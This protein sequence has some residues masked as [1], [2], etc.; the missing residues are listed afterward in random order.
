M[1]DRWQGLETDAH[2]QLQAGGAG[3]DDELNRQ[4]TFLSCKRATPAVGAVEG[5]ARGA[6]RPLDRRPLGSPLSRRNDIMP[7]RPSRC[8]LLG[9]C[10]ELS[11]GPVVAA[12]RAARPCCHRLTRGDRSGVFAHV[13]P[14]F[15]VVRM[16]RPHAREK[17]R[18]YSKNPLL[19]TVG[20][21]HDAPRPPT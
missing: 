8:L 15:G 6:A 16:S 12:T 17:C 4:P 11:P 9:G 7:W 2:G 13:S 1:G 20:R 19:S 5:R 14:D 18:D 3:S 21:P 10:L